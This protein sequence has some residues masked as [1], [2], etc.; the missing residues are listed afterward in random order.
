MHRDL[1]LRFLKALVN[2]PVR[3][4]DKLLPMPEAEFPQTRMLFDVYDKMARAYARE[5]SQG[6][7]G[8][9]PDGNF[10]RLLRVSAKVLARISEDDRYYR[11]WIG[12]SF[13]LAQR[14][15]GAAPDS[16][17]KREFMM[18][19]LCDQVES[20]SNLARMDLAD[21]EIPRG[22]LKIN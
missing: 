19:V 3:V 10:P 16:G 1:R 2:V 11:A 17:A 14:E 20:V 13:I 12:L 5:C 21:Y 15:I 8:A 7:F 9:V 4:L 6:T 22:D 18:M